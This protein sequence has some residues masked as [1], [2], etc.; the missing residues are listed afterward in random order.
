MEGKGRTRHP[1]KLGAPPEARDPPPRVAALREG[2]PE[3][4]A[5]PLPPAPG[6]AAQC[7]SALS[8]WRRGAMCR[9]PTTGACGPSTVRAP[10]G[11][12]GRGRRFLGDFVAFWGSMVFRGALHPLPSSVVSP[13][14]VGEQEEDGARA[15]SWCFWA[16]LAAGD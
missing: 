3:A 5:R 15:P 9:T 14:A 8:S 13:P 16:V 7:G 10:Q 2:S 6:A 4:P 1:Q 11:F 12:G